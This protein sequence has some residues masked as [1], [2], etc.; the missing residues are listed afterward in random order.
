MGIGNVNVLTVPGGEY[1]GCQG[2]AFLQGEESPTDPP[3]SVQTCVFNVLSM[4]G[5]IKAA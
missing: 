3:K 2:K 1:H 4:S 5:H